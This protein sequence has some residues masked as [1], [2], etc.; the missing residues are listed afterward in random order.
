MGQQK[1]YSEY[2]I[3]SQQIRILDF[4]SRRAM[5]TFVNRQNQNLQ[6]SK[7]RRE[8]QKLKRNYAQSKALYEE[9][10]ISKEEYL[11]SKENYELSEKQFDIIKL[12]TEQDNVLRST[13]LHELDGDLARMKKTLTMVY[14]KNG[15]LWNIIQ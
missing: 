1:T 15:S 6:F 11:T 3:N 8:L 4:S 7:N 14:L 12:Q 2:Q 9:E 10:L 5:E 13:S